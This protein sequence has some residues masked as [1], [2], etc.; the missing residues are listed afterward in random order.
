[1]PPLSV[2][3][4]LVDFG[5]ASIAA[6]GIS[7]EYEITGEGPPLLL[8]MGLGGQLTDW[9]PG[10]V[11]RL[12]AHFTVIR[13]D[14]RDSGLSWKSPE[15]APSRWDLFK[16][17]VWP[18]SVSAP[19][20]LSDM[21]DDT[22][23]LLD[24]LDV[25]SAHIV[26][27]SMGGMIA[28]LVAIRHPEKALSLCSIMSNTGDRRAGRPSPKVLFE[29]ARRG[30]PDKSQAL[31]VTLDLFRLVGGRDWD[32]A[33]QRRRSALSLERSYS[34]AGVLHQTVA[35]AVSDDRTDGLRGLDQST[36]VMHGLDDVL[37]RPSGGRAT[38]KAV[39]DSRLLLFPRMGHDLPATRHRDMV[40][41]IRT[42]AAR[43][44]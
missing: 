19:Y 5:V 28:Q 17:N 21:A 9:H 4:T 36:L 27:M 35:I 12:A 39:Q 26:G 34:P 3:H 20:D 30:R 43:A 2:R 41:A 1:M 23:G 13:F 37:V 7:I 42:N 11:E 44:N 38:A 16:A 15:P 33:E 25:T 24:A 8:I 22:V 32:E 18:R 14:N 31:D 40:E 6:N 29:L 10:L